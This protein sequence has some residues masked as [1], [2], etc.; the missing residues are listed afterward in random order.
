MKGVR[1]GI[2]LIKEETEKHSLG[3]MVSF[4]AVLGLI[5]AGYSMSKR[6]GMK[7]QE[8]F[9]GNRTEEVY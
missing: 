9:Y 7:Y 5:P 3:H 8:G 4:D 2:S 1:R 6:V